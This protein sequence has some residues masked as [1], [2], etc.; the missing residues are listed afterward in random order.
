VGRFHL[1]GVQG[2]AQGYGETSRADVRILRNRAG[3]DY[4]RKIGLMDLYGCSVGVSFLCP[5]PT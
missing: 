3:P 2:S 1:E 5:G 4:Y